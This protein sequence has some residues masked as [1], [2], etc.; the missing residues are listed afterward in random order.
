MQMMVVHNA[1]ERTEEDFIEILH[2]ADTRLKLVK[3]WK[4]GE[5]VA[6]S[7]IIEAQFV[8]K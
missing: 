3:V 2:A 8:D 4:G 5:N 1:R 7:A 6:A